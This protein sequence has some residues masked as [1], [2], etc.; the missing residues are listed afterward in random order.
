MKH[1]YLMQSLPEII[2]F[3]NTPSP[4]WASARMYA[5]ASFRQWWS[6]AALSGHN[7]KS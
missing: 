6:Q 5:E 7:F 3:K 1:I 4:G 2:Y